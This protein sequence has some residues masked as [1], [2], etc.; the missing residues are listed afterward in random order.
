LPTPRPGA[1]EYQVQHCVEGCLAVG[2]PLSLAGIGEPPAAGEL[3]LDPEPWRFRVWFKTPDLN[4]GHSRTTVHLPGF[5]DRV[6]QPVHGIR[7][8]HGRQSRIVA[9]HRHHPRR[10]H[11][12]CRFTDQLGT[13]QVVARARDPHRLGDRRV[14]AQAGGL[15]QPD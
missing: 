9:V 15:D 6:H 13:E 12:P 2:F 14:E 1:Y 11:Q 4:L 3:E 7:L 10:D 8:S 5:P